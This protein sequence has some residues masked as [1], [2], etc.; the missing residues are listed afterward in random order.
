MFKSLGMLWVGMSVFFMAFEQFAKGLLSLCT[1]GAEMAGEF[2]DEARRERLAK[3]RENELLE[4]QAT[5][6]PAIATTAKVKA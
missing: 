1:A 4:L 2:E 3:R 5:V 6:V